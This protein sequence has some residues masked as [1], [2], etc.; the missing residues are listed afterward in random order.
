M[1]WQ[2]LLT[3]EPELKHVER[4]CR[5]CRQQ[6]ASWFDFWTEHVEQI[7][8]LVGPVARCPVLRSDRAWKAANLH[9]IDVW[10]DAMGGEPAALS[11]DSPPLFEQETVRAE[12]RRLLGECNPD[13]DESSRA[14]HGG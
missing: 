2:T 13:I 5:A 10:I 12:F 1:D 9:L 6:G 7:T 8:R 4:S 3:R 11:W 14:P